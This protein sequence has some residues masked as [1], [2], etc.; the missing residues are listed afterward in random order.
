MKIV[1]LTAD[2]WPVL[3]TLFGPGGAQAGCWCTW[4]LQSP[5]QMSANG[6]AVNRELLHDR[7]RAGVPTGLL[8]MS[9]LGNAA[10]W[11]AVAPWPTYPR[12]GSTKAAKPVDPAEDLT[13]VWSVT[14]LFVHRTARR[15]GLTSELLAAAVDYA[16]TRGA[17]ALEGYPVDTNGE[18]QHVGG[19]YHGT[20]TGF[21]AAGFHAVDRRGKQVLVRR[22]VPARFS[23]NHPA[24]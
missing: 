2:T 3:V 5:K 7:V 16:A 14:C 8:A 17:R 24:G 22:N 1:E 6:S 4:F 18:K 23:E 20:L 12:L 15:T 10:G 11:V 13:D 9:D 21:L 19:L